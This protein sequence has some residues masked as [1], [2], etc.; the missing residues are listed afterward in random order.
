MKVLF[1]CKG[2]WFRSQIAEAVYNQITKSQDASSCGTYTGASDE[3]E[4]QVLLNLLP[5]AFFEVMES[6]GL[7][8]RNNR[9]RRLTP[10][11]L[12]NADV[13]VSMAEQPYI[14]TFLRMDPKVIWWNVSDGSGDRDITEATY[15][16][17]IGLVRALVDQNMEKKSKRRS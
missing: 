5:L 10:E 1:I 15:Q 11:M 3:P 6:H 7:D 12:K 13:A 4:G 17:I 14:P 8:L 16:K 9:T 2:N